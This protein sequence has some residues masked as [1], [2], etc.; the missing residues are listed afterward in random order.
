M[1]KEKRPPLQVRPPKDADQ[2]VAGGTLTGNRQPLENKPPPATSAAAPA[3]AEA[4]EPPKRKRGRPR[5]TR[6]A[7]A[8]RKPG[9]VVR[10]DGTELYQVT[11]YLD[12]QT[13]RKF[14]FYCFENELRMSDVAS[15]VMT[16]YVNKL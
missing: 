2:F 9:R 11:I 13:G 16:D 4:E 3:T 5:K 1:A 8:A 15:K 14:R 6:T 12:V 7:T 10:A